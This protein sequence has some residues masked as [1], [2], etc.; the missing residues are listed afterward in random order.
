[1]RSHAEGTSILFRHDLL[2]YLIDQAERRNRSLSYVVNEAVLI[3]KHTAE[4]L[5][6]LDDNDT[7]KES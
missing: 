2:Q 1:M 6:D 5:E 3:A 7:D 4:E